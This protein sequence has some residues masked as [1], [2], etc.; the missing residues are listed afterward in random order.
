MCDICVILP[1]H[2]RFFSCGKCSVDTSLMDLLSPDITLSYT[3]DLTHWS[4]ATHICVGNLNIIGSDNGLS[5]SRRQAIIWTNVGLL[6]IGPLGTN[7][8][9]T[10][11][12]IYFFHWKKMLLKTSSGKWLPSCLVGLKVLRAGTLAVIAGHFS[13]LWMITE[14]QWVAKSSASMVLIM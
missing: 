14:L 11:L 3:R 13:Y 12:E 6:L 10:L 8:N 7:F 5:P 1:Y 4:R 2:F 9:E